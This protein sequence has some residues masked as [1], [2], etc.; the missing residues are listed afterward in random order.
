MPAKFEAG[1]PHI[2]GAVGLGAAIEYLNR[3]G[4]ESIAAYEEGLM[5]YATA[6]LATIPNLR[7]LGQRPAKWG[8]SPSSSPGYH[9]RSW[10]SSWTRRHRRPG[11]PSLRAADIAALW[12]DFRSSSIDSLYNTAE[13]IDILVAAIRKALR[14]AVKF[15]HGGQTMPCSPTGRRDSRKRIALL[16]YC[17]LRAMEHESRDLRTSAGRATRCT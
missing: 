15:R 12:P 14:K 17:I 13:E 1:T 4:M 3:I 5:A 8:R 6:A 11:R 10:A 7:Q 9:R 2:A 16:R